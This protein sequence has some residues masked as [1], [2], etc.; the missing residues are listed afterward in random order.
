MTDNLRGNEREAKETLRREKEKKSW[1]QIAEK[2][3]NITRQLQAQRGKCQ[4]SEG[5]RNLEVGSKR[6][7]HSLFPEDNF[8]IT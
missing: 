2:R 8:P 7:D 6:R 4:S 3:Q 1:E 5:Q